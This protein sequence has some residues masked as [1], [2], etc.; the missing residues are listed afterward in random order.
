MRRIFEEN[1]GL[2]KDELDEVLRKAKQTQRNR[3]AVLRSM[4]NW[5]IEMDKYGVKVNPVE[6]ALP[7]KEEKESEP[8]TRKQLDLLFQKA[9]ETY[10]HML[11]PMAYAI[12][13]GGRIGELES[14]KWE[15]VNLEEGY[16]K[17]VSPK[18][19][20]SKKIYLDPNC[21]LYKMF[22]SMKK[23]HDGRDERDFK[24]DSYGYVFV[25]WN[26]RYE[27]WGRIPIADHFLEIR[28]LVGIKGKSFHS[29]RHTAGSLAVSTGANARAVQ[30]IY[31]HSTIDMTQHYLHASREDKVKVVKN[32]EERLN[33]GFL[34]NG[35]GAKIARLPQGN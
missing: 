21:T 23:D 1:K 7:K 30:A 22:E 32:V 31:G 27:K 26:P 8:F 34:L 10:P 6:G 15:N 18:E 5:A 9:G 3:G 14:L 20:K 13:T 16:V 17:I 25:Y 33:I 28:R 35:N 11:E 2:E 12:V 29:F 4:Y 24:A 19:K